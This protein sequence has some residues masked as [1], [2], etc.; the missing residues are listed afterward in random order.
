MF[1]NAQG[2]P[3]EGKV[4]YRKPLPRTTLPGTKPML[5]VGAQ[6][7]PDVR[8]GTESIELNNRG[9]APPVS[10]ICLKKARSQES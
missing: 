5:Q 4:E 9:L 1:M 7:S 2:E 10:E 3:R 6:V 8:T